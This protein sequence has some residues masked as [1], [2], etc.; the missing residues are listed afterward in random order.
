MLISWCAGGR[1]G[2][3]GSDEDHSRS[4]ISSAEDPGW[5]HRLGTWWPDDRD[6]G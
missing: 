6:V 5:S 4:R 1:C 3:M 2:M